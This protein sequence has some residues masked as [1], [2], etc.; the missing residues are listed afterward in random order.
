VVR[1]HRESNSLDDHRSISE[2]LRIKMVIKKTQNKQKT[3]NSEPK[4][5]G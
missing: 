3:K 2:I 5:E 4:I 1:G